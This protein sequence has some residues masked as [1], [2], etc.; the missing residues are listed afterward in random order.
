M[1]TGKFLIAWL[2]FLTAC[3]GGK[4]SPVLPIDAM[5]EI[6]QEFHLAKAQVD[7][8]HGSTKYRREEIEVFY[9]AIL[10]K[11][12][13]EPA[14]FSASYDYY[15]DH[16]VMLDTIYARV[17]RGLNE[18]MNREEGYIDRKKAAELPVS[19]TPAPAAHYNRAQ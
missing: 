1:K 14:L 13:V 17:I 7:T 18:K 6:L 10:Q 11:T 15:L 4:K 9:T 8:D 2:V 3:S 12:D 19:D 5:V 16:P